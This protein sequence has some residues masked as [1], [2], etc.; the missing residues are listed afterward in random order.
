MVAA[1]LTL[2]LSYE[3]TLTHMR[4]KLR[5][6]LGFVLRAAAATLLSDFAPF[7]TNVASSACNAAG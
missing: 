5:M 6:D 2:G 4:P 7:K 3:F 1:E